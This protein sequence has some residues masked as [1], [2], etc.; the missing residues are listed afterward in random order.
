[1]VNN[2]VDT[3]WQNPISKSVRHDMEFTRADP[4]P[5]AISGMKSLNIKITDL[6]HI[7][8]QSV[9]TLEISAEAIIT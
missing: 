6:T 9:E 8:E 1:V 7:P 4:M 3:G 5:S 2:A